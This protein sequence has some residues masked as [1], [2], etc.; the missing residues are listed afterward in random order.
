MSG[1]GGTLD[2][3]GKG[4]VWATTNPGAIR[5]DPSSHEFTEFKS[6]TYKNADGVGNTY[7]LAV[8]STGNAWWAQM[9]IDRVS[10]S[11]SETGKSLEVKL[12]PIYSQMELATPE[13]RKLYADSGSDWNSPVP[14]AEGP[15]RLGADKKG[16]YVWVCDSWGGNL[17]KID[18]HTLKT[19]F[20]ALP[21]PEAHQQPYH[22][23][24][25]KNHNVWV[26]VI[27]SD[28]VLKFNPNTSQWTEFS[29]PTLGAETRFVSILEQGDS[30]Q[31]TVPYS[32][33]NK[34]A[35]MTFRSK[36]NMQALA[37]KVR[38]EEHAEARA[39]PQQMK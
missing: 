6:L 31:V 10:K 24:V 15:R 3:D 29:L 2:V 16:N 26:N 17:A 5:F 19:T 18:I 28:Q 23:V 33:A 30:I 36:E 37:N 25:D 4:I 34:V 7:G 11:E 21:R 13:E 39:I 27:N 22:A 8:D 35:R 1:V 38:Q 20:V 12:A 32:R 9:A 14:W